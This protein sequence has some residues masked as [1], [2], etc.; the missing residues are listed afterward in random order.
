MC[1][2]VVKCFKWTTGLRGCGDPCPFWGRSNIVTRCKSSMRDDEGE[3]LG[4]WEKKC[5][6]L[7]GAKGSGL[8]LD[9]FF[10]TDKNLPVT[11]NFERIAIHCLKDITVWLLAMLCLSAGLP[12]HCLNFH[13]LQNLFLTFLIK[14]MQIFPELYCHIHAVVQWRTTRITVYLPIILL[15]PLK[16]R[17]WGPPLAERGNAVMEKAV[18]DS[19]TPAPLITP[20]THHYSPKSIFGF[21]HLLKWN[22]ADIFIN[23]QRTISHF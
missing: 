17:F 15:C 7:S 18:K 13:C 19:E 5:Q 6:V 22:A 2:Q 14:D 16:K 21:S 3:I 1:L 4:L 8:C 10:S 20:K 12:K 23:F 9:F 11:L